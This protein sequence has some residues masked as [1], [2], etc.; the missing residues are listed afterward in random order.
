MSIKKPITS[1]PEFCELFREARLLDQDEERDLIERIHAGDPEAL[2]SFV[3]ANMKLVI[4]R[5]LRFC[6]S[7]DPRLMDLISDGSIGL[8]WAIDRFDL[9]RGFQF[10]TY[11]VWWIDSFVRKGLKFFKKETSSPITDLK[12]QFQRA[13]KV[14]QVATGQTPTE[15]EV[16]RFL[17]WP[18]YVLRTYQKFT[19]DRTMIDHGIET[20]LPDKGRSPVETAIF[21]ENR[22][23]I[24]AVL[25]KLNPVH[26]DIIRRR[27]GIGY[28]EETLTDIASFY[29]LAKERIRQKEAEAL[30]ELFV[31]LTEPKKGKSGPEKEPKS[32]EEINRIREKKRITQIIPRLDA[33]KADL[34]RRHYG[35]GRKREP[36]EG[37]AKAYGIEPDRAH[38][39]LGQAIGQLFD[40]MDEK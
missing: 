39:V 1:F 35:V 30:R 7:K 36:L 34:I 16:A 13:F 23:R 3:F 28:R 25:H 17:E 19:D 40:L 20:T 15:G 22:E 18:R 24:E 29:G 10:S 6:G 26:E 31:L 33:V 38:E 21:E 4:S 32:E 9:S 11:A 12:T 27:Y 2:D 14:I 5:A 8:I 37:I